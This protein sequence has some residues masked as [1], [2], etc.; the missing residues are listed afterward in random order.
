MPS[1]FNPL[2]QSIPKGSAALVTSN[3]W[4][5]LP[6]AL[7]HSLLLFLS[8]SLSPSLF[9]SPI[10]FTCSHTSRGTSLCFA[11]AAGEID[12]GEY[13]TLRAATA[14]A[15]VGITMGSIKSTTITSITAS[16]TSGLL[17]LS[18]YDELLPPPPQTVNQQQQ[19]QQQK[20]QQQHQQNPQ[21]AHGHAHDYA[22]LSGMGGI[23]DDNISEEGKLL[24]CVRDDSI[25]YASTRDLEPPQPTAT[26]PPPPPPLPA[27][28]A[29]LPQP[30]AVPQPH[31]G[32]GR[33]PQAMPE[34]MQISP[35]HHKSPQMQQQH[36]QQ[37]QASHHQQA[38]QHPLQ[39]HPLP[40]AH[41]LQHSH[42]HPHP[43]QHHLV[44]PL[45]PV[46]VAV[47]TNEAHVSR[48]IVL[49]LWHAPQR[50]L[51]A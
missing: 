47:H 14:G 32:Y 48:Q 11:G 38:L 31:V 1:S 12:D 33:A 6:P 26:P 27:K 46:T 19:Q 42:P 25:T 18:E 50:L 41:P 15:V 9:V 2:N 51:G 37:Q 20:H 13:A 5:L 40:H 4:F 3:I 16:S 44:S 23:S 35:E 43:L 22:N 21:H 17:H 39:Q 7:T 34:I 30:P 24:A 8:L 45:A 10:S 28:G 49:G 36:Q 29:P